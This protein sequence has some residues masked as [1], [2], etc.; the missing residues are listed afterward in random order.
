MLI[1]SIDFSISNLLLLS[2]LLRSIFSFFYF[3]IASIIYCIL[4][5]VSIPVLLFL[6]VFCFFL[7][8]EYCCS[9]LCLNCSILFV[10]ILFSTDLSFFYH[11]IS[12]RFS[13]TGS[14]VLIF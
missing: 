7:E 11:G 14:I 12:Y 4:F 3:S 13:T 6:V 1:L 2:E 9:F 10:L 5:L 8:L